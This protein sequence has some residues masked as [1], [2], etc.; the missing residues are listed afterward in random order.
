MT[1][2]EITKE[3]DVPIVLSNSQ[4]DPEVVGIEWIKEGK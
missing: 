4:P 1:N 2:E 3:V